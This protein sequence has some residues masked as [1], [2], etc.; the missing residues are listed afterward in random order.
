MQRWMCALAAAWSLAAGA[1]SAAPPV[2]TYGRLPGIEDVAMSPS[3][4][5]YALVALIG[6]TR[7]LVVL[8][9]DGTPLAK[10]DVGKTKIRSIR[11]VGEDHILV[12]FTATTTLGM[13]FALW[14]DE[15]GGVFSINVRT[16]KEI[17]VFSQAG[18]IA[19]TVLGQY[20]QSTQDGHW[21]GYFG[22]I[23]YQGEPG[24]LR[25]PTGVLFP[26]LYRVDLDTGETRVVAR[27]R[28]SR[29]GW[30]GRTAR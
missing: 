17:S 27:P 16:R 19:H 29:G 3:G 24:D 26:D 14:R 21:F 2:E 20:G 18:A 8:A 23:S 25:L 5:A 7:M 10:T 4:G 12:D 22:G 28:T 13:G 1:A 11:W 6:D 9:S 15:L 30:W